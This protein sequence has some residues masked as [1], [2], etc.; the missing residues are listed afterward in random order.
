MLYIVTVT[1]YGP[2]IYEGWQPVIPTTAMLGP[3]YGQQYAG[4]DPLT[5]RVLL[6]ATIA[7][8]DRIP[9]LDVTPPS[10]VTTYPQATGA[11]GAVNFKV[12]LNKQGVCYFI[13][14]ANVT[15]PYM[16][17]KPSDVKYSHYPAG[18]IA[19]VGG[20][21][22]DVYGQYSALYN[23][24]SSYWLTQ[25]TTLLVPGL[26]LGTTYTAWMACED[27]AKDLTLQPKP[28]MQTAATPLT[29]VTTN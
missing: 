29:F 3:R 10:F 12:M 22:P 5:V 15:G 18:T 6:D 25:E 11:R 7:D 14:L 17:P 27:K 23:P 9:T 26:N 2:G 24:I 4:D 1:R 16:A 20:Q 13:I 28:N 21:L 19:A 8:L